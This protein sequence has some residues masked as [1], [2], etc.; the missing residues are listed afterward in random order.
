MQIEEG[1]GPELAGLGQGPELAGLRRRSG[2]GVQFLG[3][4]AD[5]QI[6][7]AHAALVRGAP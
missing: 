2:P 1:Q 3:S 7:E 6:R 5:E 4:L